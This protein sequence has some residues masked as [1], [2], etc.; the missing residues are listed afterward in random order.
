VQYNLVRYDEPAVA[1]DRDS[2]AWRFR[3]GV[4]GD[5]TAKTTILLRV[6]WEWKDYDNQAREDWDGVIAEA[7]VICV[8]WKYREPSQVRIFG[9][10]ANI[11]SLCEGTNYYVST[12]VVAE[13]RHFL[14]ERLVLRV[15]SLGGV[16]A[17]GASR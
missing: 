6:S 10:R 16:S 17:V 1:A 14:S 8:I 12:Y 3:V 11:E 5:I 15:R 7:N 13:V 2:D 4:K 9:G